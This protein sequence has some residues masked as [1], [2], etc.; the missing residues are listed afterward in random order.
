[1]LRNLRCVLPFL[2][3]TSEINILENLDNMISVRFSPPKKVRKV[4]HRGTFKR[5]F[6]TLEK[7]S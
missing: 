1:M 5:L 4:T 6:S 3:L 7:V 2:I